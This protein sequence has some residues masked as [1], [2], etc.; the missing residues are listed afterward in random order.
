MNIP[1]DD[2]T[3]KAFLEHAN[4]PALL[5]AIAQLVGDTSLLSRFTPPTSPMMGAVDGDLSDADQAA[6]REIAFEAL[7]AYRDGDGSLPPLPSDDA[8]VLMMNWCAGEPLPAEYVPLAI[9]E[10]ALAEKDPRH[11]EWNQR[12]AAKTLEDFHVVIVGAGFGGVCA[13]IRLGQAGINYTICEKNTDIG[14]TWHENSYPDLRVDVPNHFYSF[15]FE[16]NPDWSNYFSMRDEIKGYV[17]DVAKK[18]A[19]DDHIRFGT[20]VRSATYDASRA[21]WSVRIR[22]ADGQEEVLEANAVIS[23]VG[24]LNRPQTPDIEGVDS[25]AGPCFHSSSWDHD[26]D[27][28]GKRVGVIG[29]GASAMQFVPR[30]AEKASELTIFQR[31]AHWAT[32]NASYRS[33]IDDGFKW[34]LKHIPYYHSWYRFLLFWAGSD[35]VFPVFQIDPEWTEPE[36]STSMANDMFR[37]GA[38]AYITAQLGGDEA[39]M[40]KCIPDYPPLGKRPLMDNGWYTTLVQDHV[41]LHNAG[42]EKIVPEG[43][44]TKDGRTI[45]LDI[46]ILATG[47]HAGKFLWPMEI[48]G[49]DGAVLHDR[50]DGGENPKAYLGITMPEFPNLFCLYGP[51]TNPVL[52]SVIYML[53]CQTKYIMSCLREMLE[54]GY[55]SIECRPEIQD[56]Y[57]ERLDTAMN[58]MVWRHPKVSSYYNNAQ[59]RVITN[60]PWTM[61]QYWD[62]TRSVDLKEYTVE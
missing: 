21:L 15:S 54:N 35:R 22:G 32:F 23:A 53:E 6:I 13:G 33:T 40:E 37:Q 17:N 36:R 7:K 25:F 14:G 5:P 18:H 44:V 47:F 30:V 49:R 42:I 58:T 38:I 55:R 3:L 2:P 43:V 10:A 24:M 61:Y 34:C 51:N 9:E 41:E 46:L 48:T 60:V 29:T 59:G 50:W 26:L 8:L 31:S 4:L 62:M 28:K 45:E 19:V 1:A 11:F 56:E 52:G 57:Y 12:P 27:F 20:E 39:L 16:H